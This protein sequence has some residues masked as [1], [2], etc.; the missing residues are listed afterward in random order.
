MS[1]RQMV[2]GSAEMQE[3]GTQYRHRPPAERRKYSA[4]GAISQG[5]RRSAAVHPL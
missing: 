5:R 1:G 4:F 3:A 2:P